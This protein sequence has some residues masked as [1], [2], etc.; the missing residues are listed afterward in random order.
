MSTGHD[1]SQF[2]HRISNDLKK[3]VES[4]T[5]QLK[6]KVKL[7]REWTPELEREFADF[8]QGPR[9][10]NQSVPRLTQVGG[11]CGCCG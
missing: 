7:Y 10:V 11:R 9:I 3:K 8:H 1:L 2:F 6:P 5:A 4:W